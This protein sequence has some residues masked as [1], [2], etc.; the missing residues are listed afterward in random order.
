MEA[1]PSV[2]PAI[3][4]HRGASGDRPE[5]SRAAYLQAI[6]QG[7]DGIETDIRATADGALVCWHD[8]TIDRVTGRGGV[9]ADLALAEMRALVPGGPRQLVTLAELL[10]ILL[11]AGRPMRLALE[12]KQPSPSGAALDE[13][14][15]TAL[16]EAGWDP[17][18]GLLSRTGGGSVSIDIMC[19]WPATVAALR[20]R[21]GPGLVMLL[22]D[23]E[24]T[25][26]DLVAWVQ[27]ETGGRVDEAGARVEVR[28]AARLR[29]ELLGDDT[30]GLGPGMALVRRDPELVHGWAATRPV[31]V[32]TVNRTDD[33]RACLAAGVRE[34]TTDHPGRLRAD[35]APTARTPS[36]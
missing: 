18:T 19:F 11:T 20:G 17:G 21:V 33:A 2:S 13:G 15:L 23:D 30:V 5:H 3:F 12:I 32:W 1:A 36:P 10:D 35:L 25:E 8:H 7:A 26:D 28:E 29:D 4:A 34:L 24:E 27:R 22:V 31:R 6:A 9:V 16:D 14:I